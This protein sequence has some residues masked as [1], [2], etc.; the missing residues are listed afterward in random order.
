MTDPN[1]IGG[2]LASPDSQPAS[3]TRMGGAGPDDLAEEV[4]AARTGQSVL[5]GNSTWSGNPIAVQLSI[6][7]MAN[8]QAQ[9]TLSGA[10]LPVM[11]WEKKLSEP[12]RQACVVGSK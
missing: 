2:H 6:A 11:L 9:P 4:A 10:G 3:T 12:H 1:R 8:E 5:S 7:R